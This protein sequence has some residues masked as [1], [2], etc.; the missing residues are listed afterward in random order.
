MK[1][2]GNIIILFLLVLTS[3]SG[4]LD[5]VDQDKFIPSTA[6]HYA[7]LLLNEF[8][9]ST[10]VMTGVQYMTDEV[11][12]T[13]DKVGDA[14]SRANVKPLYTWQKDIELN[15][16]TGA[17]I[18]NNTAWQGLYRDIAVA[19]Y[20]IELIG[21]AEGSVEEIN[22]VKGEAYFIR[23][24][25]YWC[26]TNLYAEPYLDAEQAKRTY[27]VP[28][29]TDIG[30]N[31][32]YD[33]SMLYDCYRTIESDLEE[34]KKL[35]TVGG[36]P[37]SIYHPTVKACDLLESRVRLYK[38]EYD[39]VIEVATNVITGSYLK[40]LQPK[41]TLFISL[42]NPEVL[43]SYCTSSSGNVS[44]SASLVVNPDLV[45]SYDESD[46]RGSVFFWTSVNKE[47]GKVSV[48][49]NKGNSKYTKLGRGNLRVAE[50]YLNRAEAYAYLDKLSEAKADIQELLKNRYSDVSKIVIPTERMELIRFIRQE[51]FKELCF[52]E[53]HRWFD[54][55]RMEESERPEIVHR[56]TE[57]DVD[58]NILGVETYKLLRNDR[59]Y[60][61]SVPYTEKDNNAFIRD[62][63]RFD[64]LPDYDAEVIF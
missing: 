8:N 53:Y 11:Q 61:L 27:G 47:N 38:K 6:D 21:T 23:A 33:K 3:C 63:E 18:S 31:T 46:L 42:D 20:V 28:L 22:A 1:I 12:E 24:W 19:N 17:R 32:T 59:N 40:K 52:E 4:F 9:A 35:L 14:N 36:T 50:A 51:R 16:E 37:K 26:L 41:D 15:M 13:T 45:S 44:P 48:Y 43:Y 56:F 57:V 55:R 7:A 62:Y 64:K 54:L 2:L 34:A 58:G 60:T 10:T 49:S 29:R 5:E 39:A 25:C 30:V